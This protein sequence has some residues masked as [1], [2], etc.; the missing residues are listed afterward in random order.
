M[1]DGETGGYDLEAARRDWIGRETEKVAAPYPVE[2]EPIRRHCQMVGSADPLY[3]DPDH[4]RPA[5]YPR[6][7]APPTAI[8]I[9]AL[10][11]RLPPDPEPRSQVIDM[12][13]PLLGRNFT[14][15]GRELEFLRPVCVGD[16][17]ATRTRIADLFQKPTRLDPASL[18][19]VSEDLITNGDDALV[20]VVRNTL[21]NFR[22]E[23]EL[24]AGADQ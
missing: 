5:R 13:L 7:P 14:N 20:C 24:A 1:G 18:W 23:A 8:P 11:G 10:P 6:T 16:R 15:M 17:L 19:I 9:F 21:L 2:H 22:A 12:G 4:P 3:L